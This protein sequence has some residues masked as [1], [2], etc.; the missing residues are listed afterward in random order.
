[1]TRST[2]GPGGTSP[3]T[4]VVISDPKLWRLRFER[5]A[6]RRS[7]AAT[8]ESSTINVNLRLQV[9]RL[10]R[11]EIG[12]EL[13]AEVEGHPGAAVSA[14]YRASFALAGEVDGL[15]LDEVQAHL[16]EI[17]QGLAPSLLFPYLREAIGSAASRAMIGPITLPFVNFRS[18]FSSP[19]VEVPPFDDV[20]SEA[21][22][23][24][25][26][27]GASPRPKKRRAKRKP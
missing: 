3:T 5:R 17:A 24:R 26:Q 27:A 12:A 13:T 8:E 6:A 1:M 14:S 16:T 9:A 11:H 4:G 22:G 19:E 18:L 20:T 7:D 25:A 2:E 23:A 21:D 10:G 15:S